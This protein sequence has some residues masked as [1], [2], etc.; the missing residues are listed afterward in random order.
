MSETKSLRDIVNFTNTL[1]QML[2]ESGG[3]ITPEIEPYL[4]VKEVNLPEKIDNYSMMMD[5]MEH[6]SD[7]YTQ[8]AIEFTKFAKAAKNI[9][10][11]CKVNLEISMKELNVA[12]LV[13][14][15]YKFILKNNPPSV[16]ID[17]EALIEDAYKEIIPEQKVIRKTKIAEDLKLGVPVAGAQLVVRQSIKKSLNT[18]GKKGVKK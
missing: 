7:F 16:Q 13:G 3:E 10:D 5:R 12:E 4:Q 11:R 14:H 18:P 15:D 9:I 8:K 2:L 6:I 17:N 1:E